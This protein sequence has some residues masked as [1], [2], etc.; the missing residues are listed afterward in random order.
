[1]LIQA[2]IREC[3][4]TRAELLRK[5][6]ELKNK[7]TVAD[8]KVTKALSGL[9]GR[10]WQATGGLILLLVACLGYFLMH[11]GL[12]GQIQPPGVHRAP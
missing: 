2:H 10:V 6:E 11:D 9:Y 8:D 4:E 12:P 3:S 7:A 1:M 5:F